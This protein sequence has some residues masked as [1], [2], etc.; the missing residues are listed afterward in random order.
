MGEIKWVNGAH[1]KLLVVAGPVVKGGEGEIIEDEV[2]VERVGVEPQLVPEAYSGHISSRRR[3]RS[4]WAAFQP[5]VRRRNRSH[6]W[7]R[8]QAGWRL[9]RCVNQVVCAYDWRVRL[10][11]CLMSRECLNPIK[12]N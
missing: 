12:N 3:W 5:R 11:M 4:W 2:A 10:W 9:S 8:H 1:A 7:S 6:R